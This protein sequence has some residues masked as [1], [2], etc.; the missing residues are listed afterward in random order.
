MTEVPAPRELHQ[1]KNRP[2]YCRKGVVMTTELDGLI[3]YWEG[4]LQG[5]IAYLAPAEIALIEAT[6]RKLRELE[7]ILEGLAEE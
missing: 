6:I 2:A 3:R 1:R 4:K 7:K 5:M